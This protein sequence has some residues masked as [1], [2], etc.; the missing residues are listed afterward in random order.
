MRAQI[1]I[2]PRA[3]YLLFLFSFKQTLNI[4]TNISRTVQYKK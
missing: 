2:Y 4:L 3:K 1:H